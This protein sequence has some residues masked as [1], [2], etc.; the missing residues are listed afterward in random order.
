MH[1]LLVPMNRYYCRR[2]VALAIRGLRRGLRLLAQPLRDAFDRC[3]NV[4]RLFAISAPRL[5]A[6]RVSIQREYHGY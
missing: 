4:R 3:S 5:P 6:S 1:G 2:D